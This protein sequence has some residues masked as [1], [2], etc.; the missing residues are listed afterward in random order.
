MEDRTTM[1]GGLG[2]DETA[3]ESPQN[4]KTGKE[5]IVMQRKKGISEGKAPSNELEIGTIYQ[6]R[7]NVRSG[8]RLFH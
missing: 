7:C 4:S 3:L 6:I 5:E 1:D 8:E 2:G